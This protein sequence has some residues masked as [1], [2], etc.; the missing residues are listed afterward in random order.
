MPVGAPR[1]APS[2][3]PSSATS[4]APAGARRSVNAATAASAVPRPATATCA[5][6]PGGPVDHPGG[7]RGGGEHAR[8]SHGSRGHPPARPE[9]PARGAGAAQGERSGLHRGER[10]QQRG[11]AERGSVAAREDRPAEHR[12]HEHQ[13]RPGRQGRPPADPVGR[14][15][16]PGRR[17]LGH[18]HRRR[19][20]Q[21]AAG[22]EARDQGHHQA[23]D[24]SEAHRPGRAGSGPATDALSRSAWSCG[25]PPS[26]SPCR[27]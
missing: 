23:R 9:T 1:T 15:R 6:V 2:S 10:R 16:H 26:G 14:Q 25:S 22:H 24:R 20:Q 21:G 19:G 17:G 13:D 12:L 7:Q 18:L 27:P 8:A 3:G 11:G 5:P 4:S